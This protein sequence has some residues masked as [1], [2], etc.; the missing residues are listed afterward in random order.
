V[1]TTGDAFAVWLQE[2]GIGTDTRIA[3][4]ASRFDQ[5]SGDWSDPVPLS[6][7]TGT[8]L[9]PSPQ[10]AA[11]ASGVALVAW[12]Q[13]D[14]TDDSI[15]T[16][17]FTP[18]G[19]WGPPALAEEAPDTPGEDAS[20][21]SVAVADTGEAFVAWLQPASLGISPQ[22]PATNL[23]GRGRRSATRA[24]R[25]GQASRILDPREGLACCLAI[26]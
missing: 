13:L 1:P 25:L 5:A 14:G 22:K 16:R 3:V 12:V 9:S 4:F 17:R 18:S 15:R 11:N 26:L 20:S 21:P 10:V 23:R 19:A 2:T 6:L 24:T 7:P 8:V